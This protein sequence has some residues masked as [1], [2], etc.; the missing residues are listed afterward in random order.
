MAAYIV[1]M[2]TTIQVTQELVSALK[3]RKMFDNESYESVIWDLLEDTLELS[4]ETK[5]RIKIAEQ[6]FKEGKFLS[7][8]Q[9]KKELGL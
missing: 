1:A 2:A 5:R 4:E 9:V 8:E 3:N 7:H 6:N